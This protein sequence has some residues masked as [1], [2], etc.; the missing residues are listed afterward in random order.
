MIN[1]LK[2]FRGESG[3][4]SESSTRDAR[5]DTRD[6][7]SDYSGARKIHDYGPGDDDSSRGGGRSLVGDGKAKADTH[8][9]TN[10]RK[11]RVYFVSPSAHTQQLYRENS[12][13]FDDNYKTINDK[14]MEDIANRAK[15][16]RKAGY[17]PV[18][19]LDDV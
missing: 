10:G 8:I 15:Q 19:I 3:G 18:V 9:T 11:S 16:D 5:S 6:T 14:V 2:K 4:G 7:D 13:L 12:H 1:E 17:T